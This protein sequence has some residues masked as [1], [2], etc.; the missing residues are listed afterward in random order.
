MPTMYYLLAALVLVALPLREA[1]DKPLGIEAGDNAAYLIAEVSTLRAAPDETAKA[2]GTLK[3]VDV[4]QLLRVYPDWVFVSRF[5]GHGKPPL[6]GWVKGSPENL[7]MGNHADLVFRLLSMQSDKW[8]DRV[9]ADVLRRKPRIGFTFEQ[10]ET[11]IGKPLAKS[12]EE[13]ASG[14]TETWVYADRIVAFAKGAV[15][16]I[17]T[18]KD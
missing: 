11:A 12:S 5:N 2:L 6:E 4:V 13:T 18:L 10:V 15:T 1:Q 16:K 8:P 3:P 14:L 9:I 7:L 17:T